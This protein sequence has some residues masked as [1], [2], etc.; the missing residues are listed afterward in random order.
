MYTAEMILCT[1]AHTLLTLYLKL[2]DSSSDI[3][4]FNAS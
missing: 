2:K 4:K 3:M 1:L